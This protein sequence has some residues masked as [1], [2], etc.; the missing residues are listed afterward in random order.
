MNVSGK[1][2][3]F[4]SKV[5]PIVFSAGVDRGSIMISSQSC[6]DGDLSCSIVIG[7]NN[8]LIGCLKVITRWSNYKSIVGHKLEA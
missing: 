6:L 2:S 8:D 4:S 1:E 3:N 7:V 5:C